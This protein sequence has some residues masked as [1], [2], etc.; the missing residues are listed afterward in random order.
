VRLATLMGSV[1]PLLRVAHRLHPIAADTA[2]SINLT[3]RVRDAARLQSYVTNLYDPS[4]PDYHRFLT[5]LTFRRRFAPAA[6]PVERWL[7]SQGLRLTGISRNGLQIGAR[8][9]EAAIAR[10]FHTALYT[11][12]RG[13]RH[14]I[15]NGQA[16][17]VPAALSSV[18]L[19]VSGLSTALRQRPI[20][21]PRQTSNVGLGITPDALA[22]I[23]NFAPLH[24]RGITGEGQA[25]AIATYADYAASDIQTY[26]RTFGLDNPVSRVG[27]SDGQTNGSPLGSDNG[28]SET[29]MDIELSEAVAPSASILVYE[30]PNDN[31]GVVAVF[32]RIVSDDRA[33]VV[34]TSWG[35]D[36][37]SF[38]SDDLDA[39]H[40]SLEEG[41]AQ[42]QAFFAASGDNGAYDAAG[43]GGS[44]TALTVDY[45]GSDPYVTDVGGTTLLDTGTTYAGETTWSDARQGVG[46]GGGLSLVFARP[47]Y[48]TG[49]GV[50]NIYS[51]GMRQV[52]DVASD[53]DPATGYAIY[54]PGDKDV[55]QWAQVGGTSAAAPVW[56]AFCALI[57][58]ALGHNIGFL[59]PTLYKLGA[60]RS[61]PYHDITSG[62]NLHY[63][64]TPGWDYATGWGS[65]DG[66]AMISALEAQ[67]AP[68]PTPSPTSQPIATPP[69]STIAIQ[70][71][72]VLHRSHGALLLAT[73]PRS[74]DTDT[75]AVL[76]DTVT[77]T[78]Q[79]VGR[80]TLWKGRL[81]LDSQ[82]LRVGSYRGHAALLAT[83]HLRAA[84]TIRAHV[85][86]TLGLGVAQ[87]DARFTVSRH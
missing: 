1:S 4:S 62:N 54:A 82:P 58:N 19:D 8:G 70:R 17:H 57:D 69:A 21:L 47:A 75:F 16:L 32:N 72:L 83:I 23:Y 38:P 3:L 24:A 28:Q 39:V 61:S 22:S 46:S 67:P 43:G 81:A 68:A 26:D 65:M 41:A 7:R 64:A 52:P 60:G 25:I 27:V 13:R 36:E 78:L 10:T 85:R 56:A 73:R 37:Q 49:P 18:I 79:P 29:E 15:A 77:T 50:A 59:N 71:I 45:P 34:T 53:A 33:P 11:Y 2:L 44:A 31:A 30:A 55:P 66:N 14:F 86:I 5:P 42:G 6:G 87:A 40:Q 48:Q 80:V 74:G 12:Q 20:P 84:G 35:E 9:S 63:P 51:N 76:Y